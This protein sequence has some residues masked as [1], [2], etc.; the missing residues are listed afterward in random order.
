MAK[1][2]KLEIGVGEAKVIKLL[3]E[4]LAAHL[5]PYTWLVSDKE[6]AL[7]KKVDKFLENKQNDKGTTNR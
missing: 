7:L 2:R 5:N 3:V 4:W 6:K 1:R